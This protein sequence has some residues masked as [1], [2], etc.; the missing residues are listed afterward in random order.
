MFGLFKPRLA[1]VGPYDFTAQTD[2]AASAAEVYALIDFADP[3]HHRRARGATVTGGG[4]RF[5]MVIPQLPDCTF[6]IEVTEAEAPNHYAYVVVSDPLMGRM[7]ST[8]EAYTVWDLPGGGCTV[9]MDIAATLQDGVRAKHLVDEIAMMTI[10][11]HN[12]LAKLKLQVEQGVDAVH[13]VDRQLVV[14]ADAF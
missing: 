7:A 2:F 12:T 10:A 5:E 9:R 1:P 11:C 6:Y 8:K 13:A 3:R 4:D 14:P